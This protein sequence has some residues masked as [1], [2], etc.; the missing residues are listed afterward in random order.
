MDDRYYAMFSDAGNLAMDALVSE[1]IE[2]F[3]RHGVLA[4][5]DVERLFVDGLELHSSRGPHRVPMTRTCARRRSWR[6]NQRC[7][8]YGLSADDAVW[9]FN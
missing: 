7:E 5:P 1:A 6:W 9:F 8:T 2:L 4:Y 3:E